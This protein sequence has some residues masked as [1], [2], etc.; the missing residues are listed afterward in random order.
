M[1][2]PPARYASAATLRAAASCRNKEGCVTQYQPP[3]PMLPR[4]RRASAGA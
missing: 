1:P 4:Q 2:A 3:M